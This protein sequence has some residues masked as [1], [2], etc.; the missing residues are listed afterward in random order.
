VN[1][2][3]LGKAI[4]IIYLCVCVRARA[5]GCPGT[6]ACT[7]ACVHMVL[8]IQHST[9]ILHIVTSF[10]APLAQTHFSTLSLKRKSKRRKEK[11]A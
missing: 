10:E 4:R 3:C 2:C 1:Y 11:A 6:W 9:R 8:L 7:C 5:C